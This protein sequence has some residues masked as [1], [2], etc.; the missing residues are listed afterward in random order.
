MKIRVMITFAALLF[1]F[2]STAA[3]AKHRHHHRHY[4][5]QDARIATAPG[6]RGCEMNND[7]RTICMDAPLASAVVSSARVVSRAVNYTYDTVE[8]VVAHPAG[9]PHSA[10]CGCGTSVHVFGKP[11]RDLYLAANWRKF[12]SASPAPGMVAWRY[13]HVFAIESVNGDGT[14][15]AYD[16]NSGGHQT[17]IHTVSL[18]GFHVVN[19][20]GQRMA[21]RT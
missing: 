15:V 19:P 16:P 18:H 4:S 13:G 7:G 6:P 10:F 21:S 2:V 9:C 17:R 8:R 3:E 11:V 20:H 1:A 5:H 12:P 14:V